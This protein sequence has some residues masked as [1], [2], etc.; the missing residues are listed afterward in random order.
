MRGFFRAV[1]G[2]ISW[3]PPA[4]FSWTGRRF[5]SHPQRAL[6]VLALLIALTIGGWQGWRWFKLRPKPRTVS[7]RFDAPGITP[8]KKSTP[9][10]PATLEPLPLEIKFGAPVAPLENL[11]RVV[12]T[13]VRMTPPLPGKWEWKSDDRL[14]FTPKED[15]PADRA[16]HIEIDRAAIRPAILLERYDYTVRTP[17]F[18]GRILQIEFYQDPKDPTLKHITATLE[19]TH[20]VDR[21]EIEKRITIEMLGGTEVFSAAMGVPRFTLE[22]GELQRTYYFRT[23]PLTLPEREDFFR[24]VLGPGI[25]TLQGGAVTALESQAKVR[26]PDL[27]SFFRIDRAETRIVRN[28]AGEP[29]QFL[30]VHTTSAAKP[31][32]VAKNLQAWMLPARNPNVEQTEADAPAARETESDASDDDSDDAGARPERSVAPEREAPAFDDWGASQVDE[33]VLKTATPVA[34]TVVPGA[35]ESSKLHTFR[36]RVESEGRM[37]L[38]IRK[39]VRAAG[40]FQ[41]GE[42]FTGVVPV[43]VPERE[44]EIQGEGGVLALS[45]ER[46]LAIKSRGLEEIQYEIARVPADQINHLVSQT[47]GTFSD[48]NFRS[49]VFTKENIA[50][51]ALEQQP[52]A[53][54]NRFEANYTAFNFGSYLRAARGDGDFRQG[55][56]FIKARGWDGKLKREIEDTNVTRFVLVTDLGL[57]AKANADGT[58]EV[59]VASLKTGQPAAGVNVDI[60]AKNGVALATA[61]T[62]AD[63]RVSL[64]AVN[65]LTHEQLPVAYVARRGDDV[66]FLPYRPRDRGL[67]FSRFEVGG[68]ESKSGAELDAFAFTE[69]GVYRPGDNVHVA[70]IVH[71]RD[72]TGKLEGIPCE[73]DVVDPTGRRTRVQKLSLP[74]SGFVECVLETAPESATGVYA[75]RLHLLRDGKRA[76]LLGETEVWVKEFLPD[77]LKITAQLSKSAPRGWV[78]P[79]EMR[80]LVS[81]QNLY[82]TP[83]SAR[84]VV[85]R[86]TLSPSAF[87]FESYPGWS[88]YD[89]LREKKEKIEEALVELGETTTDEEGNASFDLDLTRFADA[90]YSM[91]FG[92][93]GFEAETGRSVATST[94]TLVSDLPYVV[95]WKSDGNLRAIQAGA[96]RAIRFIALD[97]DAQPLAIDQLT[98][99][100]VEKTY[101]SVLTR[102][103][104]GN[105]KYDSVERERTASTGPVQLGADG[106]EFPLP[107]REPGSFV[108]EL[109]DSGERRVARVQF[110]VIGQ[111]AV[112]RSL[113]KTA[114]LQIKLPRTEFHAGEMVEVGIV[115]PYTGCGLITLERDKVYAH[116]W[117][118]ADQT[119]TV[120]KIRLP[121]DFDGTGYVNVSFVR[122]LDSREIYTS[123][124]SYGVVPI[125][126]NRDGR[127]LPIE[128]RTAAEVKPGQPLRIKYRTDRPS[129]IAIFAVDKGILQVTDFHLPDPLA[130]FFRQAALMVTTSQ[131]VDQLLPEFSLLRSMSATGGSNEDKK[132]LTLNPFRRVTDKPVVFWS[133]V[134]QADTT[135]REVVYEVPDYFNGT[136]TVM[137]VAC[138]PNAVG[139][140]ETKS[141]V[142]GAFVLTPGTPTFAAPGDV[143]EVGVTVANNV[144]NSGD[145]A[146]V[147][148][149]LEASA[150]FEILG[151]GAIDLKVGE[152]KETSATFKLR[153]KD[154]LGSGQL[155]F[156]ASAAGGETS[157]SRAT[158]SVRP[159]A[160]FQTLVQSGNFTAESV[161]VP[162]SRAMYPD[163]RKLQ[164]TVSLV[165]LGLAHGLQIFLHN[166]PNGC[167][168]QLVSGAFAQVALADEADF[169]LS[170]AEAA[171]HLE[172]VFATLQLRQNDQGG[173]GYWANERSGSF[174][175]LTTYVAHFLIDAKAAGFAPPVELLPK[176]LGY[177][178]EMVARTPANLREARTQAYAILLLTR[179][180]VVTTNYI[181]NLRDWLDRTFKDKM[182]QR[183]LTGV[184]LAGA[185]ALLK[186]TDD[187]QKLIGE[188]RVGMFQPEERWDFFQPLGADA[189][190]LSVLAA[191]FP[192]RLK[193]LTGEDLKALLRP[194][195]SGQFN[196]LSAAYAVLAL[197]AYSQAVTVNAPQLAISEIES[198]QRVRPLT[199][200]GSVLL[201]RADF[202]ERATGLRFEAKGA[203]AGVGA[204]YQTV[205]A[206]YDRR[207]PEAATAE[208]IEILREFV[209]ADG[210]PIEQAR[211]GEA[212]K[213]RIKVRSKFSRA[214]TNVAI[215]DLLPGGFE[216]ANASLAPGRDQA[217]MDYVDVREDRNIFFG[218]V[219]A[220][221]QEISYLIKPVCRGEF[222]VPPITAE[223][224]YDTAIQAR[225][226]PGKITV[227]AP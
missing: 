205:E 122:G 109:I 148:L 188:Y 24:L 23:A 123:P 1:L 2:E 147:R 181:V 226:L 99:R 28:K 35:E 208:G 31:A 87:T 65:R 6:T 73:L 76:T 134:V 103:E 224:M 118:K 97:R 59:F 54:K 189:Q 3:R 221:A 139:S 131:I 95:G 44:I 197:K 194:I 195:G 84:R 105:Y 8:L 4:W 21:A 74:A 102:Q 11:R 155:T 75:F 159:A 175:F 56:F 171:T 61:Q 83:A 142:R 64:P 47:N 149:Q 214:I 45:G 12:G 117:F 165:P 58:R 132:K 33:D 107:C 57:L 170:R 63:G 150:H 96:D 51:I 202:S 162:V 192:E 13:G 193:R 146:A 184:Y 72:W 29:E 176:S 207:P 17:P 204:F 39:G 128:L 177:L 220:R 219:D 167:T 100:I 119:S 185:L 183:D 82:G 89:P 19:F 15:W 62:G 144:E 152:G 129:Q 85:G 169:G 138:S 225:G 26:V 215:L 211:V 36:F 217:G 79:T 69:R 70:A 111:G 52:I 25:P 190:Y 55:L 113:D 179:E 186:K 115:A 127:R 173:F 212:I 43:P 114:E 106:L 94:T 136:L 92:A 158:V 187:A 154:V 198:P 140:A 18:A 166:Y 218:T 216:I 141:L 78:T 180:G 203:A 209:N 77:R 200:A 163:F 143:F 68:V 161:D 30:F 196:T 22:A 66:A 227:V 20:R 88:F 156:R 223:S 91:T 120:Q 125:T 160:P 174:D 16:L 48:P 42:D 213:V 201:R 157:Q 32:E 60:L 126:V 9:Q 222:V 40:D 46:K 121:A 172:K 151:A 110:G 10:K 130:H 168:E 80:G 206:G 133:G 38:I 116:Q 90:S 178:R 153:V 53:L 93:E 67:D 86:L 14:V 112:S 41:L 98:A 182:W 210:K 108:L 124:L 34:L 50:R 101:V 27:F 5:K 37:F 145:D 164:A 104:N 135:E 81:L 199:L 49:D 7:V 137:A 71:Q 191:Q